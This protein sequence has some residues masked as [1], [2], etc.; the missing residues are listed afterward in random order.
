MLLGDDF[1]KK[2]IEF[3]WIARGLKVKMVLISFV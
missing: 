2:E 3:S 1:F